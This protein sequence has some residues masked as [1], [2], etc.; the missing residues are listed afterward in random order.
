[1]LVNTPTIDQRIEPLLRELGIDF[2]IDEDGDYQAV[3]Q[4]HDNRSQRVVISSMTSNLADLEIRKIYSVGYRSEAP[5]TQNIANLL[6]GINHHSR[7]G[8]WQVME[9]RSNY[10][11]AYN[12]QVA[13]DTDAQTLMAVIKAVAESADSIEDYL[14]GKDVF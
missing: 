5:L 8:A 10:Y 12:V 3:F 14:T 11:A 9:S 2:K 4:L 1:M 6:L 13:A 7:L